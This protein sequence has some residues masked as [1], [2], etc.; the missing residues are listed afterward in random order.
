MTTYNTGNPLGSSAA[1]D[2]YDNSQNLDHFVN[3][4]QNEHF[5][6]RLGKQ[7]KTWYGI[8]KSA[9]QA[10]SQYGYITKDSFE[11]GSTLSLANECLRWKSNGEYYRWDGTLPKVVPPAST[12]D[13]TGGIGQGK[14]VSVGDASLRSNLAEPDGY[15]LIGGLAEHYSLPVK[16]VVVDNA[17]YNG[18]LK[19]ALTAATP[20]SVFWL[21][22]KTH[23]ITGLYGVNRNTIEN[24]T[25]VGSG[26]PQLSSDKTR[27]IDGTGTIIQGSIKNQARGFKIFN[28]GIDCGNYVSQN[29]YSTETYED[30]LQ[31]YA[32]GANANIE[33][34]N[35][36]TLNSIGVSSKPGTHSILMEQLEG[37]D[38]GYVE[39]IGGF[40]GLTIKCRNLRGDMAHCYGQYGDAF[41][42]KSDSGGPCSDIVIRTI[43]V[44]LA[45]NSGWPDVTIG[46]IYDAH[47]NVSI[48][49]V[50][51]GS[52]IVQ[53]ASW[54]L[55]PSNENTGYITNLRINSYSA[56][57]VYGNYYSLTIDSRCV[58]LNIGD[59]QCSNTSGGIRID[60]S[61]VNITLG[62]GYS[63]GSTKSGY[64]LG[65]NSL[66]HGTLMANENGEYGVDYLG[67]IGLDASLIRGFING[68]GL[69][70]DLPSA[71]DGSPLN[72]WADT[73]AFDM[74]ITGKTVSI[75]GSLTRGTAA[76]AYKALS[77]CQP[78][79]RVTIPAFGTNASST[80]VPVECYMETDGS[81]NVVGFASIPV[82]GTIDFNGEYLC[83]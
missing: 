39:C 1:K 15:Q 35:V 56:F 63:K 76:T 82:G 29:V 37:V 32:V 19:S 53:N 36:K 66:L 30:A 74:T 4:Q 5:P 9:N 41:I 8:E 50:E 48:D 71:K 80:R 47:D 79:K 83:K 64:A 58:G 59:H 26:M 60:G 44:G 3:D 73:G 23:N 12:P 55:I 75:T 69:I 34:K 27:F 25:I 11:D 45:D 7:R 33:I 13:S 40:H 67:G 43:K 28:L 14:W 49:N 51:I 81:L 17:P 38:L 22:K 20:G 62:N 68:F 65:G 18:D 61:S 70:S 10:I 78:R 31:H 46:G 77:I 16:F 72:G 21:G 24:I 52:L 2:L 42:I 54:G 6:D 57:N